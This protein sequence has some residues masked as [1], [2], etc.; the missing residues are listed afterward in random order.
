M[1]CSLLCEMLFRTFNNTIKACGV[2][3]ELQSFAGSN[4]SLA[5][6]KACDKTQQSPVLT[7]CFSRVEGKTLGNCSQGDPCY[8][9]HQNLPGISY[10]TTVRK[11]EDNTKWSNSCR[12]PGKVGQG[13]CAAQVRAVRMASGAAIILPGML[14][15]GDN[16][17]HY[18]ENCPKPITW[19]KTQLLPNR[20]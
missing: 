12:A 5:G 15:P 8:C 19:Q 7:S 10:G 6:T 13:L 9:T 17:W 14:H 1:W 20:P 3:K 2:E 18:I 11:E 16:S 4:N